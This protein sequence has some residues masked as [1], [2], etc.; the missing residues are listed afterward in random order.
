MS[1]FSRLSLE[2]F[3]CCVTLAK[4]QCLVLL[5]VPGLSSLKFLVTQE[6]SAVRSISLDEPEVKSDIGGLTPTSFAP[7]LP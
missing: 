5:N 3:Y 2:S 4:Q 7:P 1:E 6:A